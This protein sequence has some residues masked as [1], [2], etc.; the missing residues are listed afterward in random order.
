MTNTGLDKMSAADDM[1]PS[2]YALQVGEIEVLVISDGAL[3]FPPATLGTNADAAD[4]AAWRL[5]WT[6]CASPRTSSS[7]R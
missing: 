3:P 4:L 6:T 1:V 7:G 2:R 5:G